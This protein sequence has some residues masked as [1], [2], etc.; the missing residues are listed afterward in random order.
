MIGV[1]QKYGVV[2]AIV[3]CVS[4]GVGGRGRGGLVWWVARDGWGTWGGVVVM[5]WWLIDDQ[6]NGYGSMRIITCGRSVV[7]EVHDRSLGG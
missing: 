6:I 4:V 1:C 2:G 3:V 7:V 5:W